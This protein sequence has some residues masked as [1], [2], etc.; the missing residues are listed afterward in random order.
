[1]NFQFAGNTI[2]DRIIAMEKDLINQ[3]IQDLRNAG[4]FSIY[5]N[6][7]TGVISAVC[8]AVFARFSFWKYNKR[9]A[10]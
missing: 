8:L 5:L 10:D 6:E 9:R 7:S 1:M 4:I 3:L 2:K